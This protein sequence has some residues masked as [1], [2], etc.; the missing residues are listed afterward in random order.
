MAQE[1]ELSS[2]VLGKIRLLDM[3]TPW[4]RGMLA[5][6][7]RGVGKSPGELPE[8]WEATLIDAPEAWNGR[9]GVPSFEQNAVHAALT[10]YALHRQGKTGSMNLK[11]GGSLGAAA[12]R[13]VDAGGGNFDAVK[14]RFDAVVTA[15]DFLELAHH[16]RGIVQLLKAADIKLDYPRFALDLFYYQIPS[17]LNHVRLLWGQAFY[18]V[19]NRAKDEKDGKDGK[20]GRNGKEGKEGKAE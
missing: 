17:Q 9:D 15:S 19:L 20:D 11:E 13:L 4:A 10:L 16:A 2:F 5:K 6:L 7:R 12:A 14:R 1:N 18:G 8:L 3:E